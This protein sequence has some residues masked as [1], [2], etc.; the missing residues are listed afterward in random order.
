MRVILVALM[1]A[2]STGAV[3]QSGPTLVEQQPRCWLGG[4]GH[5]PGATVRAGNAVMVCTP[6]FVWAPTTD[7]AAGCL[8]EGRLYG[9]G[10]IQQDFAQQNPSECRPDGTWS[11]IATG[12]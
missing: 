5:S 9:V 8:H 6:G 7:W 4:V 10:A 12:E 11:Q 1:M 3:A 2:G